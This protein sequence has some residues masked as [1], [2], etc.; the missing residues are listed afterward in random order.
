MK[1]RKVGINVGF[2]ADLPETKPPASECN[3]LSM[4]YIFPDG[5]VISCCCMNEQNRR[6][7]Q[8]QTA[9]GNVFETPMRDI[10]YGE[11]YTKLRKMLWAKKPEEA[12]PVCK[13][14]NIYDKNKGSCIIR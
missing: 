12:H 11:K 8:R 9:M 7:W 2:N 14:C 6:D 4:P 1:G 10:W 5:T 3:V 13:I